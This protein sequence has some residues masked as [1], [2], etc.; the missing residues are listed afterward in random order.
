MVSTTYQGFKELFRKLLK[1]L[2]RKTNKGSNKIK[3]IYYENIQ[4]R[5]TFKTTFQ[6]WSKIKSNK[7]KE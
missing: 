1:I 4:V 2:E 7:Y 6:N 5:N 3:K